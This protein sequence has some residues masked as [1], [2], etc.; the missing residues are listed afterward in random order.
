M[1]VQTFQGSVADPAALDAAMDRW[2]AD[3][4]PGA[5][6]WLGSTGGVTDDGRAIM[7]ARFESPEAAK[8]NSDRPEQGAWWTETEKLFDGPVTFHDSTDVTTMLG[9]G[10]DDAGFVQI[11]QG[12]SSDPDTLRALEPTFEPVLRELHTALIGSMWCWYG[13]GEFTEAV[14][15]TDEAAARAG[16]QALS[17]HPDGQQ[18][19]AEFQRLTGE[20]TFFDLRSPQL[21]SV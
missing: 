14:Y 20:P 1:F 19:M 6:G 3:L 4:K 2:I 7:L 16:E 9:G 5:A 15:F 21:H 17:Q 12:K 13:N 10:S 11:L 8:A 18:V